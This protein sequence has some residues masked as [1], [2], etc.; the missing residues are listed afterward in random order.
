MPRRWVLEL[1]GSSWSQEC[2]EISLMSSRDWL[3]SSQIF[4]RADGD[5]SAGVVVSS[6]ST[7]IR[8]VWA[9]SSRRCWRHVEEREAFELYVARGRDGCDGLRLGRDGHWVVR[10]GVVLE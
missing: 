4:C 7:W 8:M 5:W 6:G 3:M 1:G 2:C 9:E 10:G